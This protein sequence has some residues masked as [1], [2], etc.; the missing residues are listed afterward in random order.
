LK[1]D[2]DA[3]GNFVRCLQLSKLKLG[4][5]LKQKFKPI[6]FVVSEWAVAKLKGITIYRQTKRSPRKKTGA[7]AMCMSKLTYYDKLAVGV[8]FF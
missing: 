3:T 8:L 5:E 4:L 2:V 6:L 7:Q 1:R